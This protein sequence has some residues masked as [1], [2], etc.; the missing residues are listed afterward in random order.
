[1]GL[2]ADDPPASEGEV[3]SIHLDPSSSSSADA[4]RRHLSAVSQRQGPGG[5]EYV[6]SSPVTGIRKSLT[7]DAGRAGDEDGIVGPDLYISCRTAQRLAEDGGAV[8]ERQAV[9]FQ[10]DTP[11]TA[12]TEA[13]D[14]DPGRPLHLQLTG[15]NS[16][17]SGISG[18]RS[19]GQDVASRVQ[20]NRV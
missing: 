18:S 1:G 17:I 4:R 19:D 14:A 5:D 9:N 3:F 10:I 7:G 12:R 15:G 11:K 20:A 13:Q 2:A 6:G 8:R 16:D